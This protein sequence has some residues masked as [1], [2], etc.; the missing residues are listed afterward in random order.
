MQAITTKYLGPTETLGSR[1]KV[2]SWLCSITVS[3]NHELESPDA[4]RAAFMHLLHQLNDH[5]K[6]SRPDN[7]QAQ[8]GDWFK[9]V[10]VGSNPDGKG[11][12]FIVK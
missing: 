8:E 9:L 1:I 6:G 2:T 3:Y 7:Q 11:Y 10:A 4:H 12:T 5:A